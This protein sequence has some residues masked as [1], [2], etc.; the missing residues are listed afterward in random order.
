MVK[1]LPLLPLCPQNGKGGCSWVPFSEAG[2]TARRLSH[3]K[4]ISFSTESDSRSQ[5]QAL[6]WATC[7]LTVRWW[8]D[9]A[10]LPTPCSPCQSS[11]SVQVSRRPQTT[12]SSS[13]ARSAGAPRMTGPHE[14]S[15]RFPLPSELLPCHHLPGHTSPSS[16]S[17]CQ[18][19][20]G[21]K[22]PPGYTQRFLFFW[23]L[24]SS[25]APPAVSSHLSPSACLGNRNEWMDDPSCQAHTLDFNGGGG[26][27]EIAQEPL[28]P[29][30]DLKPS[31]VF[32]MPCSCKCV[33]VS[34][35]IYLSLLGLLP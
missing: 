13:W 26:L 25:P 5:L 8:V 10:I 31:C 4:G 23:S 33:I 29:G 18:E 15:L 6:S 2:L 19:H 1:K 24:S 32:C 7:P 35:A 11:L 28:G 12:P 9:P 20:M 30:G 22:F 17:V 21:S 27:R 34:E 16:S 3:L 14:D